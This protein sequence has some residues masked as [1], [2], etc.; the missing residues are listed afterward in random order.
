MGD[1]G[2]RTD[3]STIRF[4]RVLPGP[5]ERVWA[6]LTDPEKRARWLAGGPIDRRPSGPVEL[7]FHNSTLSGAHEPVPERWRD[8]DCATVRGRVV[9]CDPPRLLTFTRD[10]DSSE[11]SEVSFELAALGDAVRLIL[12][13]RRLGDGSLM[14][15]VA[16]G[17]HTHL[18]LLAAELAGRERPPFWPALAARERDY[19]AQLQA[20]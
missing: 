7:R 18:E 19:A 14:V 20:L 5:I 13:H 6:Y 11:P 12:T 10:E 3:P 16:S 4:E 2:V 8:R 17:W 15:C 1:F 9:A